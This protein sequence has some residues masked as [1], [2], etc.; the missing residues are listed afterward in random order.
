MIDFN[1]IDPTIGKRITSRLGCLSSSGG[2]PP[3]AKIT[4]SGIVKVTESGD[5]KVIE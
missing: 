1:R 3:G 5:I 4:E 2:I